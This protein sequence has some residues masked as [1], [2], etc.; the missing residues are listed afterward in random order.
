MSQSLCQGLGFVGK[1]TVDPVDLEGC[2]PAKQPINRCISRLEEVYLAFGG[3]FKLPVCGDAV[4]EIVLVLAELPDNP[5]KMFSACAVG[6]G[7]D[8]GLVFDD[9]ADLLFEFGLYL[10]P[11][12]KGFQR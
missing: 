2:L 7:I 6:Y 5:I 12:W 1:H 11:L 10:R 9:F 8:C 4:V 3:T